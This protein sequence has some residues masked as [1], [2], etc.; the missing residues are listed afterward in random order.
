MRPLLFFVAFALA[1]CADAP[2]DPPPAPPADPVRSAPSAPVADTARVVDADAPRSVYTD[3]D[4]DACETL[5]TYE[6]SGGVEFRCPG[7]DGVDLFVSEGD[8]RFDV[9]AGVPN[10]AFTTQP[11][12][13][14]LGARVEWRLVDGKPVAVIVRYRMD[15]GDG[16]P[17]PRDQLAVITV[18]TEGA[19]GC[20]VDWVP[21]DAAPSQNEA[22][23]ALADREAVGFECPPAG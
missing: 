18:G 1:A 4:L 21:A 17:P 2:A 23:R 7:Y 13:N 20:L 10:G 9:D 16:N 19:P 6:E 11:A 3:L 15:A 8:L 14:T 22:A 5:R 12:F